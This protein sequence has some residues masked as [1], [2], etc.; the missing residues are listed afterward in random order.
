[1]PRAWCGIGASLE[2]GGTCCMGIQP[3]IEPVALDESKIWLCDLC[4]YVYYMNH[5]YNI[6]ISYHII[7]Y[8]TISYQ[9]ASPKCLSSCQKPHEL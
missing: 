1:M 6:Y 5:I 8:H 3:K 4:G 7:S 2:L 9:M